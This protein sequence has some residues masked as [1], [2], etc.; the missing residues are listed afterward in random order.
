MFIDGTVIAVTPNCAAQPVDNKVYTIVS[1]PL[2]TADTSPVPVIVAIAGLLLPHAPPGVGSL[3]AAVEPTHRWSDPLMAAGNGLTVTG[4]VT[5]QPGP[6][7]YVIVAIPMATPLIIPVAGSAVATTGLLLLH[8][9]P[10]VIS[11]N[12]CVPDKHTPGPPV[13]PPGNALTV[14]IF[15]AVQPPIV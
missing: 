10:A 14:I 12:N 11:E 7:E 13:I 8:V 1:A 3:N 9:P 15:V 6:S 2:A 5:L 4:A